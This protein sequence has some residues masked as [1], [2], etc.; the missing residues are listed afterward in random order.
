LD[1]RCEGARRDDGAGS[2]PDG[3]PPRPH[4]RRDSPLL[5]VVTERQPGGR[6]PPALP[7]DLATRDAGPSRPASLFFG[8]LGPMADDPA[9]TN[10]DPNKSEHPTPEAP[11]PPR[12]EPKPAPV[13]TFAEF[14]IHEEIARG[15][16]GKILRGYDKLLGRDVVIKVPIGGR[17]KER[18]VR[19]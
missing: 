15:G 7:P 19:E 10:S 1:R 4:R 2:R 6:L 3:R 18:L 9:G 8:Y 16:A 14:D 11:P 13:E 17:G 12:V 5:Q